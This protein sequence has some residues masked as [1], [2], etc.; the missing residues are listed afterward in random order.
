MR[1]GM[2]RSMAGG[3]WLLVVLLLAGCAEEQSGGSADDAP[4]GVQESLDERIAALQARVAQ[5]PLTHAEMRQQ[6][7]VLYAWTNRLA[8]AGVALPV[9]LP[10]LLTRIKAYPEPQAGTQG[11]AEAFASA[12][13]EL[14]LKTADPEAVGSLRA[15]GG[16]F[17]AGERAR[18]R[19]VWTVGSVGMRTGGALAVARHFMNNGGRLQAEDP[20]APNYLSIET[21]RQGVRFELQSMPIGGMH[22]GFR[23]AR[24]TPV[25]RLVEGQLAPGDEVTVHY[26]GS[27][28]MDLPTYS[29][30]RMP[31]PLYVDLDGSG[32]LLTLPIQPVVI[33]GAEVAGV[34]GFAPSILAIGEPFEL[35]VRAQDRWWNRASGGMPG[36]T[37][38][39]EG[40]LL[41]S[42]PAGGEAIQV[43]DGL[44]FDAPGVH[45]LSIHSADGRIG[46][47][48]N[49]ILVQ[50]NP[51]HR[52]LWGDTHGHSGFAEGIGT[53][54]Q[55]MRYARDDA[56]LD[57]VTHSEH[58][59]WMDDSEWQVL[60][61][62]VTQ[63]T[64]PGR[65]SP[66][67]GYEWTINNYQGGHH[68]VLFRTPTVDGAIR[69]R[70]A[71][72][73]YP[74][75]SRL[76][77]GLRSQHDPRD[78]VVIPHAH[79]AGDYRQSDPQLEPL[80]E[81]MSMHGSFEWFGRM[82]LNH[83][84]R[85]G[86]VAA[87]D[88]HL[89]QPGYSAGIGGS[90][91]QSGGLGAV[92]APENSVDAVFD[93]MRALHAY[94][95]S[96]ER[97]IVDMSVNGVGMGG[98]APYADKRTVQGRVIGTGPIESLALVKNDRVIWSRDYL[99]VDATPAGDAVV[100]V[101][102][103]SPSAPLQRGDNPRGWRGWR[104]TLRVSGA[105]LAGAELMDLDNPR[106]QYVRPSG[107]DSV[108]FSTHT[109][110]D[111]SS[112][113]LQLADASSAT[114]VHVVLEPAV[115]FGGAP[116]LY[117]RPARFDGRQLVLPFAG[118]TNGRMSV[119]LDGVG[120]TDTVTLRWIDPDAPS[121]VYFRHVDS[122]SPDRG[123]W[124]YL[125][126]RQ[127]DDALAWSS[128]VWVGGY[129]PQ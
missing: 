47:T 102:F 103:A 66:Y 78:V 45:R 64:D 94:A 10:L 82:Y 79:Q 7:P 68:N 28:G 18:L 110:G 117:R 29:S 49:P 62:L 24:D 112:I 122:Q 14:A 67:L 27:A 108:E 35:S 20:D 70:I 104:G 59:L 5:G 1:I 8:A 53:P 96:G 127:A 75:L 25:F 55:F 44:R 13:R 9:D 38:R 21:D 22:G 119:S 61:A 86:F 100:Y 3:G 90:L 92:L 72:M 40:R 84:H 128:P 32:D 34:A 56:R 93:A 80:V 97:I 2:R 51:Q 63:Y 87:S 76:Y 58:D 98:Q 60:A 57:F 74:T 113:R 88:N 116:R 48:V 123:D 95:T 4:P 23:S 46:G 114:R 71:G 26:G 83:G 120:A 118:M 91:S 12:V 52:I 16:P 11:L 30:E 42:L 115:E 39:E 41:A 99:T 54:D 37:L 19:Q 126:V 125:R 33:V 31:Y 15:E 109:R 105:H 6:A 17:R 50:A 85:V 77:Q 101:Q 89:S 69:Q 43:V 81:I 36:W 129:P 124:Y 65:F 111:T 106:T 121:Q 73:D 107:A